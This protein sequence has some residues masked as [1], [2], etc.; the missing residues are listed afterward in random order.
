M[1][2]NYDSLITKR[3]SDS[4][5]NVGSFWSEHVQDRGVPLSIVGLCYRTRLFD[6]FETIFKK[7]LNDPDYTVTNVYH[8][9]SVDEV[10][11]TGGDQ[12]DKL[13]DSQFSNTTIPN[14]FDQGGSDKWLIKLKDLDIDSGLDVN[15]LQPVYPVRIKDPK[16]HDLIINSDFQVINDYIIFNMDPRDLFEDN[17]FLITSGVRISKNIYSF[18]VGIETTSKL[19]A[20]QNFAKI[21]QS[22]E[23][24]KLAL[25][26]VCNLKV[27]SATQRLLHIQKTNDG[28]AYTFEK[29]V[30]HVNYSHETLVKDKLYPKN[31]VIG[32][33]IK[34]YTPKPGDWWSEIDFRGGLSLSPI[35]GK[36][37]ILLPEGFVMAYVANA[38]EGST[39]G[40]KVN[41]R[42]DLIGDPDVIDAYWSEVESREVAEDTYLNAVVKIGE[43]DATFIDSK[44]ESIFSRIVELADNTN[45]Q[46]VEL[47]I[48]KRE[49]RNLKRLRDNA[50]IDPS[51]PL[52]EHTKG[53][54]FVKG[55]DVLFRAILAQT[56]CVI[57]LDQKQ[58]QSKLRDVTDFINK[59]QPAGTSCI[60]II[61]FPDMSDTESVNEF[62]KDSIKHST[63]KQ[64]YQESVT[65]MNSIIVDSFVTRIDT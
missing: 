38:Q 52:T 61:R 54:K 45:A 30:I 6:Q 40:S 31:T 59:E 33:G 57:I 4:L 10:I 12:F 8:P 49:Y 43:G 60:M 58:I 41:V 19:N 7:L 42:L 64:S 3:I 36:P 63:I 15:V 46:N 50:I 34:L 11:Y 39:E 17:K 37:G 26:E 9:F 62:V 27:T 5:L 20:V 47:G 22:P 2:S 44:Y 48:Y 32:D 55:I 16:G 35:I 1:P 65:S 25:A 56:G 23:N 28:V 18:P 29:E 51:N 24:F 53:I 13:T 21:S 14:R